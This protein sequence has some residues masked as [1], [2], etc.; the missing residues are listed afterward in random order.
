MY[1]EGLRLHKLL[2]EDFVPCIEG[3]HKGLFEQQGHALGCL[4]IRDGVLV[5]VSTYPPEM[6][7][8]YLH[9]NRR[10]SQKQLVPSAI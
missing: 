7:L 8:Q 1:R 5:Q 3:I 2:H 6:V 9:K 10:R 4:H